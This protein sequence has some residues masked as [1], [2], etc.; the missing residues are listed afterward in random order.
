MPPSS[1]SNSYLL[2]E[3]AG[4]STKTTTCDASTMANIASDWP[5]LPYEAWH[6]TLDTLHMYTQ[7]VGKIRLALAPFE[8][9]WA[10]TPL[11]LTARGL[12][13]SPIPDGLD[14]F[15]PDFGC[16]GHELA[17][18]AADG[19]ERVLKLEPPRTV[20][21]FYG[22][23]MGMLHDAGIDVAISPGPSEVPDPIPFAEDTVHRSYDA[24]WAHRWWRVL[25][26]LDLVVKSFRARFRGKAH[27]VCFFWGT[28]DLTCQLFS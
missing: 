13:T 19:E 7:V 15:Q 17:L 12:T 1:G 10:N 22:E 26:K 28:F 6:D 16:I 23:V 20:A 5:E 24:Q 21:E 3:P 14:A 27:P 8:P 9:Q 4:I 18:M 11:Y 25:S 2:R